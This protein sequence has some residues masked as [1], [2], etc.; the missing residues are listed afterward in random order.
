LEFLP[1]ALAS[2]PAD[3]ELIT[4]SQY[5]EETDKFRIN[6]QLAETNA[7]SL[8]QSKTQQSAPD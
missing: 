1:E 5:L 7:I 8:L 4:V 3:I 2:L 6:P